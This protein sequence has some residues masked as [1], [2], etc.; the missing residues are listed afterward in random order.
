[1]E[2]NEDYTEEEIQE[3]MVKYDLN[4]EDATFLLKCLGKGDLEVFKI[5]DYMIENHEY[6]DEDAIGK[7]GY[8]FSLPGCLPSSDIFG[9]FETLTELI[10]DL[11][12]YCY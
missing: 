8:W 1:M 3:M 9:P 6:L 2:N 11:D 4:K 10:H 5:E 12:M 7:W